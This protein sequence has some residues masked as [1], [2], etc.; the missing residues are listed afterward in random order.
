MKSLWRANCSLTREFEEAIS[1]KD[2]S[3]T[4]IGGTSG[5]NHVKYMHYR[6]SGFQFSRGHSVSG[7]AW[8]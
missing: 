2:A 3:E 6:S 1:D 8:A 5:R 4:A 7:T